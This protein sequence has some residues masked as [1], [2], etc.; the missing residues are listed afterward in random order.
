MSIF[1]TAWKYLWAFTW[2]SILSV[3]LNKKILSGIFI[4][5]QGTELHLPLPSLFVKDLLHTLLG[6]TYIRI[7]W[8]RLN[9]GGCEANP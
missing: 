4:Q 6:L 3:I 1:S 7:I 2:S 8:Y 9:L 5:P